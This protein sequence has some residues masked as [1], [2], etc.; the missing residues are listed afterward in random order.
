MPD[1]GRSHGALPDDLLNFHY[2]PVCCA[3]AVGWAGATVETMRLETVRDGNLLRFVPSAEGR[4]VDVV[5]DVDGAEF[6]RV[7]L[8][9]V[10][11][12]QEGL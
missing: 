10:R 9:A 4:H 3:V 5:V 11:A 2:D 6:G 1:L 7:W 12:A 8:A